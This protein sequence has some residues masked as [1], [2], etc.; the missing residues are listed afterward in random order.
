MLKYLHIFFC[1]V[2]KSLDIVNAKTSKRIEMKITTQKLKELGF[3]DQTEGW[4]GSTG[5]DYIFHHCYLPIKIRTV[6]FDSSWHLVN[7][8]SISFNTLQDI[9][10]YCLR[11][12]G[13]GIL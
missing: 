8:L 6:D 12:F 10:E 1:I 3:K 13:K 4:G 5:M 11:N 7:D 9:D 2:A